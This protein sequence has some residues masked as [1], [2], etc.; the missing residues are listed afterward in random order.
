[1]GKASNCQETT[2]K[3]DVLR[4]AKR[5]LSEFTFCG[6]FPNQAENQFPNQAEKLYEANFYQIDFGP[7]P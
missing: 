6:Q 2:K 3:A 4:D 1:L 5:R 7:D